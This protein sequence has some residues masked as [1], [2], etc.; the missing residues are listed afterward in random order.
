MTAGIAQFLHHV[1]MIAPGNDHSPRRRSSPSRGLIPALSQEFARFSA[2]TANS[3]G[4]E[5]FG[6]TSAS[7]HAAAVSGVSLICSFIDVCTSG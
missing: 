2:P 4:A 3:N 1:K 5:T 7:D 6:V